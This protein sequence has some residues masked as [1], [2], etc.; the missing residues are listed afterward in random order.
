MSYSHDGLRFDVTDTGPLDGE[1]VVLLHGFPQTSASWAALS[2]LL[3]EA[4]Y[5]TIAPDQRGYSAG[6]RPRGRTAYRS[7]K[8]IGDV[9]ALIRRLDAGPVHLVGHDWGAAVAW[10][11]AARHPERLRS[12]AAIS[13]AH[14]GAFMRSML[15]SD[16]ARRS[17]YFLAFQPP[18]LP[19]RL[20]RQHGGRGDRLLAKTGLN[21]A[22]LDRLHETVLDTGALTGALNWYR[23]MPFARPGDLRLKVKVPTTLV[24][25]DEDAAIGRKSCELSEQYVD[26]PYSFHEL[27]GVSHWIPEQAPE[28]TA[29][30]LLSFWTQAEV[31]SP[32]RR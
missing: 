5:R 31:S 17:W 23:A 13:V 29:E 7:S 27:P 20:L 1:V 3:H 24:W 8:L 32:S 6:A 14:P 12:L 16:Q 4:G 28:P 30:I 21:R 19:E 15:S 18:R 22:E 10:A 9:D 11:Y 26:A 2:P 25:S